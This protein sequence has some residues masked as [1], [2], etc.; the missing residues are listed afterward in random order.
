MSLNKQQRNPIIKN[1][2]SNPV[3]W[4]VVINIVTGLNRMWVML[5]YWHGTISN[6]NTHCTSQIQVR[7]VASL[8]EK[9]ISDHNISYRNQM[10]NIRERQSTRIT[11]VIETVM[12][13]NL[14]LV[15]N[16]SVIINTGRTFILVAAS[17][18][19]SNILAVRLTFDTL[20]CY[21]FIN[22]ICST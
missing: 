9:F 4:E 21:T 3:W 18:S 16:S 20:L 10:Q 12:M 5:P 1:L 7:P 15:M 2:V 14:Q 8:Y 6:I 13:P 19:Q 17:S 22:I 11:C